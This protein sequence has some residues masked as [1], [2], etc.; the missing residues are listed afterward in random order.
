MPCN[1][2]VYEI[3]PECAPTKEHYDRAM[4]AYNEAGIKVRLEQQESGLRQA[5]V[6]LPLRGLIGYS[7]SQRIYLASC[8]ETGSIVTADDPQTVEDMLIEVLNGEIAFNLNGNNLR[9]LFDT[10]APEGV[11]ISWLSATQL[12]FTALSP[13]LRHY[14][15]NALKL[16][17]A[18][19]DLRIDVT[20][21]PPAEAVVSDAVL[22]GLHPDTVAALQLVE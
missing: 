4:K 9:N 13:E 11:W 8:L 15:Y 7:S 6:L 1:C 19:L 5:S 18:T 22:E 17:V 2:E 20:K 12:R 16:P 21:L 10:P 3:C 14:P